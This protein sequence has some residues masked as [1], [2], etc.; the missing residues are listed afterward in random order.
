MAVPEPLSPDNTTV[1]LVDHAI[2][3]ANLIRSH[4]LSQH[5]NNVVGLA[6]TAKWYGSG[7]VV[8]NGESTKPSGP[9]YPELLDAIGDEPVIERAV[10]FNA[11]LDESFA[12][13]VRAEGRQNLAIGGISTEGCVL[14]TVLGGLREGYRVHVVVDVCASLSTEGHETALQRMIQAG[15]V[16]VTWFSLAAEFQLQPR[17][18]DA[19]HRMRL[20]QEH[21]PAMAMGG[22]SFSHA[23]ELGKRSASD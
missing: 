13:A 22:R 2:G 16:P 23:L 15:A 17:W 3:F 18:H 20:M 14:Q 12:A 8:T 11:F 4:D 21:V 6:K 5:I 10:D 7:L 9:L 1:V 19:P